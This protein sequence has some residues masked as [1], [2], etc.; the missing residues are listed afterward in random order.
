MLDLAYLWL[1]EPI[2]LALL[3]VLEQ[4]YR[5]TG[6]HGVSLFVLSVT[7]NLVLAPAYHWAERMQRRERTLQ[8]AMKP[9]IAEFKSAFKGQERHM[10]MSALYRQHGYH[11]AYALRSLAPLFIQIP[12]FIATFGLLSHYKP[13]EGVSFLIF[14]DLSRPDALAGGA[15]VMPFVM[16]ALNL[17]ALA[18]YSKS[19]ADRIQ[20]FVVALVF[21]ALLYDSPV[22]LVLYWTFN[23]AIS[24]VKGAAYGHSGTYAESMKPKDALRQMPNVAEDRQAPLYVLLAA[25]QFVLF[26]VTMPIAFTSLEDNVDGLKGYLIF[27]GSAVSIIGLVYCGLAFVIYRLS[28]KAARTWLIYCGLVGLLGGL[29]FGLVR[30]PEAG[31]LDNFVFAEPVAL[32]SSSATIVIDIGIFAAVAMGAALL[33]QLRGAWL[34]NMLSI[35]LIACIGVTALGVYSLAERMYRKSEDEEVQGRKLFSFSRGS[36][37]VLIIFVDG[38]MSGYLPQIL[39]DEPGLANK[40]QGFTWHSNIVSTGNRTINGLPSVFGGFDYTVSAVNRRQ[41][42]SLKDK[43]SDAYKI[44]VENF[45]AKGYDV[46]YS[47]PFWF[48]LERKGDCELFNDLYEKTGKGSCIHSIGKQVDRK[49]QQFADADRFDY[50]AGLARQYAAVTLFRIAPYSLRERLY[51]NGNWLGLSYGWKKKEDKYLNNFLSLISLGDLSDVSAT[52]P[53]FK[54]ITNE[55]TRAPLFLQDNCLPDH[56]LTADSPEIRPLVRANTDADTAAI[57]QTT[58]CMMRGIA[59]FMDWMRDRGIYSNTMVVVVSDHG[60]VSYNPLLRNVPNQVRYSMFQGF[61]MIKGFGET[62]PLE[63]SRE[64]IANANVPGIVCDTIGGCLDRATNKTIRRSQLTGTV[65]LHETPWQASGQN[66]DSYVID[67]LHSVSD[68]VTRGESWKTLRSTGEN[69]ADEANAVA[70]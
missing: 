6:N 4:A 32:R 28:G 17:L 1:I 49:R 55:I 13:F 15:N 30:Q 67:A 41:T 45:S 33:L 3:A 52:T 42:G 54:F 23:N 64:F 37:N 27:F 48:G 58:K 44:Y 31:V 70:D 39:Q 29:T 63:Q 11:P 5:L 59:G 16:T 2:R 34:T 56:R 51:D 60:W 69:T 50:F 14:A 61:L 57:Y 22:G 26:G 35:L 43:V 36:P 47:D 12:F 66:R 24:V 7:F 53:T 8:A 38:A 21:L 62:K 68:D 19:A 46:L 9:K 40:L 10:M 65:L 20:G 18:L 25:S